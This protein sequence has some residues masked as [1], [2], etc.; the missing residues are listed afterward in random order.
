MLAID[1]EDLEEHRRAER[2]LGSEGKLCS[3]VQNR[4]RD[5]E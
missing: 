3:K 5:T 4:R 2:T 1:Q